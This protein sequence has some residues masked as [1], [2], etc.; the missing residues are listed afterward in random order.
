M[1]AA[2]QPPIAPTDLCDALIQ[3]A[4]EQGIDME[5]FRSRVNRIDRDGVRVAP[6]GKPVPTVAAYRAVVEPL[7]SAQTRPTYK[8]H[9]DRLDAAHGPDP[10]DSIV[11]DDLAVLAAA[12]RT[13]AAA[14]PQATAGGS[15]AEENFVAA[16]RWFFGRAYGSN[17]LLRNPAERLK[18]PRRNRSQRRALEADE[19]AEVAT[20]AA[21]GGD[22]PVLDAILIRFH[23][24]TGA[25][26]EGGL[27][28]TIADLDNVWCR[29]RLS[30]KYGK[31]RWV[32]VTR[33]LVDALATFANQRGSAAPSD[34]VF[35]YRPR[36]GATVG[37][38]LT[39]RRYNTLFERI[40]NDL[41]WAGQ[42]GV[43]THWLRHTA[44]TAMERIGGLAVA[45]EFL[46]HEHNAN[47]TFTYI[48]AVSREVCDA[49]SHRTGTLH[50][51]AD[52][53]LFNPV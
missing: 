49:F 19:L 17:Y 37:A 1:T 32:P 42:L 12:A 16:M 26:R 48:R 45:A 43:S 35:R 3:A 53:H 33:E 23:V 41:E 5:L 8:P 20:V 46:G 50:P 11:V 27:N 31:V 9:L 28:L 15:G 40:Q 21:S 4:L 47:A 52:P 38:P 34:P 2:D 25:R 44:G 7:L 36:K 51:L 6:N 14:A 30:E 39:R 18:K 29:V 10:I 22:D 13:H 24:E